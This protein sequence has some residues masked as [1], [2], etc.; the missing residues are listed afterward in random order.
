MI[1]SL[2]VVIYL[3]Q[4]LSNR[5]NNAKSHIQSLTEICGKTFHSHLEIRGIF[6]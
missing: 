5:H 1:L 3:I 4:I 6:V 2:Q